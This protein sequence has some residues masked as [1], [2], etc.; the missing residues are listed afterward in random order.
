MFLLTDSHLEVSASCHGDS[1]LSHI[2]TQFVCGAFWGF[3]LLSRRFTPQPAVEVLG[4]RRQHS[5][6]RLLS[7]RFTPQPL[8]VMWWLKRID[9]SASCHGDSHLSP[10]PVPR[11]RDWHELV[12]PPPVTEIHPSAVRGGNTGNEDLKDLVSASCHGDSHLSLARGCSGEITSLRVSASC[13]GDSHLSLG[14]VS[15]GKIAEAIVSASCHG[16]SHLSL[17]AADS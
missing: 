9:V 12:F 3:R 11:R 14:G 10:D 16:D 13:H 7:R 17:A 2:G 8:A 5:R 6:F 4:D 1:H 15:I